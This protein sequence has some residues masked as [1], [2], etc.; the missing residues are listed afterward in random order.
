M[1][2]DQVDIQDLSSELEKAL[3]SESE[4]VPEEQPEAAEQ[5]ETAPPE[6][7][8]V[9]FKGQ[10]KTVE[11]LEKEWDD[12]QKDYTVK[13]QSAAEM[14]RQAE[15]MMRNA[16]ALYRA[17]QEA[18]QQ[19]APQAEETDDEPYV[20]PARLEKTIRKVLEPIAQQIQM[21]DK[22]T[23]EM[24]LTREIEKVQAAYPNADPEE[25]LIRAIAEHKATG[26]VDL[27]DIG[28][29]SHEK[30]SKVAFTP[31]NIPPDVREKIFQAELERRKANANKQ[32]ISPDSGK[33]PPL[34]KEKIKFE[35]TEDWLREQL[36]REYAGK[37]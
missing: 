9:M 8:K 19:R 6:P 12:W 26:R 10:E 15:D 31:D 35:D 30:N 24:A 36:E 1:E 13:T 14:K 17:A 23:K 33:T 5:V 29:R 20:T 16:D 11:E 3:E 27:M 4:E 28:R 37:R 32:T 18:A 2:K 25:V 22:T 34:E 7:A 21:Q